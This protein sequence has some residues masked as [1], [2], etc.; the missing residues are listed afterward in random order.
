MALNLLEISTPSRRLDF[1]FTAGSQ[2]LD[3]VCGLGPELN[4]HR[5]IV[6]WLLDF[7]AGFSGERFEYGELNGTRQRKT[8]TFSGV[9]S[10]LE[11]VDMITEKLRAEVTHMLK[12][13]W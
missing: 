13:A 2:I 6:A 5:E 1:C 10:I 4:Q 9:V 8:V 3:S 11:D 12:E 7:V